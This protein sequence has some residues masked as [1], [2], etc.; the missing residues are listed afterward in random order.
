MLALAGCVPG[1]EG[2]PCVLLR[3]G[4]AGAA[5]L[6]EG[7]VP[8]GKDVVSYGLP[9]C[10]ARMCVRDAA[11]QPKSGAPGGVA[12]GYCTRPCTPA[13]G[14][15]SADPAIPLVCRQLIYGGDFICAAED[16]PV[17]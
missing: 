6:L 3:G 13:T 2:L 17:L 7:E 5:P 8:A 9:D 12:Q 4:D 1:D 15:R 14:C 16:G 10:E 11:F